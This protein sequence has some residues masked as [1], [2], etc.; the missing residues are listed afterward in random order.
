MNQSGPAALS[1]DYLLTNARQDH[2]DSEEFDAR[3]LFANG[4]TVFASYTH[5]SA[6]TNAAL[7]YLPTPSPLGPQQSGP[8]AW[9]TP[10]RVISWGWLPVPIAKLKK[11]WDFVYL[12]DWHTGF[13]F[14]AVNAARAGGGRGGWS[15]LSRLC[16]FQSGAGMEVSFSRAVLGLA[17]RD[18]ECHGQR[19]IPQSS[20][21]WWTRRSTEPSASFRG[22]HSRRASG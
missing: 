14:T 10:N 13:P 17:R 19:E 8:L 20:T 9:D 4:Y 5:S 15:A 12:L 18:G 2:Y 22:G 11:R 6:R 7:D 3:R 16:Q 1:G 21:M